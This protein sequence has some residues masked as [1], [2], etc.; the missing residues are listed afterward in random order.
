VIFLC[1]VPYLS[2]KAFPGYSQ[3][4]LL[5]EWSCAWHFFQ[6]EAPLQ[7]QPEDLATGC[8][9]PTIPLTSTLAGSFCRAISV[10]LAE[11]GLTASVAC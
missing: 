3:K 9:V 10:H 8:C 6:A 4:I 7:R 11:T 5:A 1:Q 2:I